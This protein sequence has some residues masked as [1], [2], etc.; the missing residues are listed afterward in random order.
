MA[1]EMTTTGRHTGRIIRARYDAA[2]TTNDNR[3]HWSAADALSADAAMSPAVR[4]VLRNR[5]RYEEANNSFAKGIVC[6]IANDTIGTGPTL[7]VTLGEG[8]QDLEKAIEVRFAEWAKAIRLAQKMR[9]MRMSRCTAG[10]V[11]ALFGDNPRIDNLVTLDV[12]LIEAEQVADPAIA[13]ALDPNNSDGILHDEAGNPVVYRILKEHPGSILMSSAN[14]YQDVDADFVFHYYRQDRPGQRR[15]IP[16][17][18][19]SIQSFAE[20]RRYCNAVLAAAET[21]ADFAALIYTDSPADEAESAKTPESMDLVELVKRM[22]M[23]LPQGYKAEQLRAEQ[24]TTTYP[25]FIDKKLAEIARCLNVPFT[26]AALDSS[27]SNLSARYLDAQIYNKNILIDRADLEA[28]LDRLLKL[29]LIWAVRI[30]GYL[31]R[32]LPQ[33]PADSGLMV[34]RISVMH[35]WVWPS[36]GEHAD[37]DKVASAQS[38]RLSSGTTSLPREMANMGLDWETEQATAARAMGIT[39]EQYR[40]LLCVKLFGQLPEAAPAAPAPDPED[41]TLA[42]KREM[43]KQL[44]AVPQAREAVYNGVNIEDLIAASGLMPEKGYKAPYAAVIA[45]AGKL[46]S[47]AV[48]RDP[49]GDIVGGDV[50]NELPADSA[51]ATGGTRNGMGEVEPGDGAGGDGEGQKKDKADAEEAEA[52]P[53]RPTDAE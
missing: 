22:G 10:E 52:D 35:E 4:R 1:N 28:F 40:K 53:D 20:L 50:E 43:L 23:V 18:T 44:L 39:V 25:Q 42:W 26:I 29:W 32:P 37:P 5:C 19:P 9:T 31:P 16:E 21:A 46:V 45:P 2:Q 38:Q 13:T 6:T 24:P 12:A 8:Y 15:G 34:P 14:D 47:G 30:P 48:V 11:F 7:Q 3:R 27:S 36:L 17:L 33:L 51:S 41:S 49:E